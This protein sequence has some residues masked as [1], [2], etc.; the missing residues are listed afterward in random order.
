MREKRRED[1]LRRLG[2]TVLRFTW[3]DLD[4]PRMILAQVR[5]AVAQGLAA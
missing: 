5:A 1:R 4:K 2:W 3:S